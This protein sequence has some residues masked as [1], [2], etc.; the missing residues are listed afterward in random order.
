MGAN[1]LDAGDSRVGWSW[2]AKRTTPYPAM[3]RN[4]HNQI[5]L[6]IPY[7]PADQELDRRYTGRLVRWGD[8]P[9]MTRFDYELPTQFWFS[10]ARGPVSLNGVRSHTLEPIMGTASATKQCRLG[11]DYAVFGGTPGAD[12]S[13][14][15]GLRTRVDGLSRWFG[16]RSVSDNVHDPTRPATEFSLTITSPRTQRIDAALNLSIVA[17]AD[18]RLP[19]E[20]GLTHLDEVGTIETTISRPRPWADHLDRHRAVHQLLEL[21]CWAP[22]GFQRVEA[23]HDKDPQRVL[24][25][26]VVGDR[27]SSV[28]TYSLPPPRDEG[29]PDFLFRYQDIGATGVRRWLRLRERFRRGIH[30]M[31]FSIRHSGTSLDGQISDA[32]IGLEE[33]GHQI[34]LEAGDAARRSHHVNLRGIADEVSDLLPFRGGQWATE[35]TSIYNDVKHADRRDPTANELHEMLVKN[36]LVFRVWMARRIGVPDAVVERSMWRMTRGLPDA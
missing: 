22:L 21:G 3:L 8:D 5:E 9:D 28:L 13:A 25:G 6:V 31:T 26:D 35:S 12:H 24:S 10:D 34:R 23:K 29:V 20:P 27:W 2:D 30:A 15:N 18:W 17:G 33:I 11:I 32:G 16:H 4:T 19:G 7:D 14:V 36:R 1:R